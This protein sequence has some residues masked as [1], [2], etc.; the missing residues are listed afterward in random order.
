M[1]KEETVAKE[2]IDQ[3]RE[4]NPKLPETEIL[5]IAAIF[6]V[7]TAK[8]LPSVND[9]PPIHRKEDKYYSQFWHEWSI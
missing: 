1:S 2:L 5:L 4:H 6:C 9:T 8:L 3:L 7:N